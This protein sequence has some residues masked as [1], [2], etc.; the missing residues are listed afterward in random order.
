MIAPRKEEEEVSKVK[1]RFQ[2]PMAEI[3]GGEED[4]QK[5][6]VYLTATA[7]AAAAAEADPLCS[8]AGE[9]SHQREQ[10]QAR[11]KIMLC[12]KRVSQQ[13]LHASFLRLYFKKE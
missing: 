11:G 9:E 5:K 7:A 8:S 10:E 6:F 4:G 2:L 1:T 3:G 13:R 12:L